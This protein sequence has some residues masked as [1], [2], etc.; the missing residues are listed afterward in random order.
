MR[1]LVFSTLGEPPPPIWFKTRLFRIFSIP[2]LSENIKT[3][4]T[5]TH[6]QGENNLVL[7]YLLGSAFFIF[8]TYVWI[9]LGH[10]VQSFDEGGKSRLI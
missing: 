10:M 8:A 1:C 4:I 6:A 7:I 9:C 3:V 2:S 5:N